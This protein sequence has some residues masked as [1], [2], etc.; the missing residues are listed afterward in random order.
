MLQYLNWCYKKIYGADCIFYHN[1][2]YLLIDRRC[3]SVELFALWLF[4]GAENFL[5]LD[6]LRGWAGR[7]VIG[8]LYDRPPL[9]LGIHQ[10]GL[11][12]FQLICNPPTFIARILM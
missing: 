4:L 12:W 9:V 7:R 8:S 1:G 5:C 10:G 11:A 3:E 2:Q 6:G